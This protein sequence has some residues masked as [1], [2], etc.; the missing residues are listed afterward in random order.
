MCENSGVLSV[1]LFFKDIIS[2]ISIIVPI[3]LILMVSVDVF[4][5]VCGDTEVYNK[6]MSGTIKKAI[7]AMLVFFVPTFVNLLFSMMGIQSY[8]F[9]SCWINANKEMI[10]QVKQLEEA[11]RIAAE[12]KE[13]SEKKKSDEERIA[14]A[15]LREQARIENEKEAEEAKKNNNSSSSSSSSGEVFSSTKYNLTETQL[16]HL[17]RVCKAEQ[18]SVQGAA[19]EATL[20]A[21]LFESRYKN[22]A[23]DGAA[24]Y[25][26]VRTGRWFAHAADH[27]D[28]GSYTPEILAAVK[29]VLVNGNRVMPSNVVEH[30]CWYCN[31]EYCDNGV[32]GD[33]CKIV[34]GGK[35][36]TSKDDIKNRSNYI[37][38]ETVIY[39]LYG[40][41]YKFYMFPSEYADPFGYI[42]GYY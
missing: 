7:A 26:Y 1:V 27:M 17:A 8:K 16:I 36:L 35:T 28:N 10:D 31:K 14:L 15:E 3:I 4:K 23:G 21:N 33:I 40:S 25:N 42:I 5:M 12:E 32:Q 18:G 20:M 24:L 2:F 6:K 29:D 19:A 30:D 9:S 34:V 41:I 11:R 37:K 39:N 38:D 22:S 13:A